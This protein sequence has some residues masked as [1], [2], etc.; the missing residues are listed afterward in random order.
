MAAVVALVPVDAVRAL[1]RWA[2]PSLL[3]VGCSERPA[4]APSSPQER[5]TAA[6]MLQVWRRGAA[7][8]AVE[9]STDEE[10]RIDWPFRVLHDSMPQEP[11]C[12]FDA[13]VAAFLAQPEVRDAVQFGCSS[14]PFILE[15]WVEAGLD[16]PDPVVRLR[17]LLV[18]M[19]VH[20]PRTVD[21]Q[22]QTLGELALTFS[23][24]PLARVVDTL[25]EA[26]AP[27]AIDRGIAAALPAGRFSC[28]ASLQWS[29]RAAGVSGH[30]G[31]LA[32]LARLSGLQNID[33]SLAAER[34]IEDF[35]G[36][37]AD[38]ALAVCT[39]AWVYDAGMR[40]GA[41]LARRNPELLRS[42]LLRP[43]FPTT[44]EAARGL[45]LAAIDDVRCVP[46]L[47][48]SV[49]GYAMIDGEMF[50]AIERLAQEQHGPLVHALPARVRAEQRERATRV[51]QNVRRRFDR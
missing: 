27:D 30:T 37:A 28:T 49:P 12:G 29:V 47:C 35:A 26:F 45:L 6:E 42:V 20:A 44:H 32:R 1:R 11:F 51:A 9:P 38:A 8:F 23:E 3:L 25:R 34:S 13:T 33:L 19:R 7:A 41:A 14:G 31:S 40:A 18:L 10:P 24:G 17:A 39:N 16:D 43:D 4:E 15:S 46:I 21:R 48:E 50:D 2:L 36:P 5:A 22:W